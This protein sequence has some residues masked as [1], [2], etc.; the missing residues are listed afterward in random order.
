MLE[1]HNG[2]WSL[3]RFTVKGTIECEDRDKAKDEFLNM[4]IDTP[5]HIT[6]MECGWTITDIEVRLADAI[7]NERK[8]FKYNIEV[9]YI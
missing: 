1:E 5:L 7:P 4:F 2:E 3:D 8:M 6:L 9:I